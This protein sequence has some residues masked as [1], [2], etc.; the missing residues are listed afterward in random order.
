MQT[1]RTI[2][3]VAI[4]LVLASPQPVLAGEL[5]TLK[6]EMMKMMKRI[7]ELEKQQAA[8]QAVPAQPSSAP[9][10]V[11]GNRNVRVSLSGHVNRAL[12]F[13]DD[14]DK[15]EV[16][17]VD[18][19]AS[20]TRLRLIGE[21]DTSESTT[22]GAAIEVQFESNS[23]A[24]VDQTT[25]GGDASPDNFTQRRLEV[26]VQDENWG[27]VWLGQGWTASE[28]TS[29]VDLSG[30]DLAG[31]SDTSVIAGGMIFRDSMG[32][33]SGPT[34]GSVFKNF[35]GLGRDDRIRYD[36]PVFAGFKLSA[37]LTQ[38]DG[39]D[40]ALRYSADYDGTK[41]A[42]ALAYVDPETSV[43]DQINGSFSVLFSN[44]FNLT[45]AAGTQDI[46]AG[47][48]PTFYYAKA[49]YRSG[50]NAF[51]FDI[52]QSEDAAMEG[53]E[54]TSYGAQYVHSIK[55]WATEA[56]LGVRQHELDRSGADFDDILTV[57]GGARVKF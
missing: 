27:R 38:G 36:T 55:D 29:E 15:T 14:G 17:H 12:L 11:S 48:D 34:I 16:H 56:Y 6:A 51:S 18:N 52:H 9:A 42:A 35:D 26:Y 50:S 3:A 45:F 54:A 2:L 49:G 1:N 7:E 10:I 31:Y 21:T 22:V 41:V 32:A 39:V 37:S 47:E 46:D 43:E 5:E 53:D 4:G 24:S 30:T 13:V 25:D 33:L 19:D 57:T 20:S 40:A 44:G 8:A 28:G 23:S